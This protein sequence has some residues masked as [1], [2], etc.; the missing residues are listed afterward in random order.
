MKTV[1]VS[2]KYQIS[3]PAEARRMLGI[4]RG[5]RLLV[6]V[7]GNH[8]LLMREPESYAAALAGLHAEIW[9]GVDAQE[10]VNRERAGWPD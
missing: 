7:R 5:D 6:D 10:Y 1:T 9:E 4:K 8:L 3:L 2:A